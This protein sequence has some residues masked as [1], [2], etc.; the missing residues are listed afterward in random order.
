MEA[1]KSP[2]QIAYEYIAFQINRE[3]ALVNYRMTWVLQ[4][5]GFLLA[6]LA[7]AGKDLPALYQR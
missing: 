6:A 5:N 1:Q 7:V 2:R 3:D 4:L